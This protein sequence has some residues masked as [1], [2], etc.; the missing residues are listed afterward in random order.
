[1]VNNSSGHY[2][3]KV[4]LALILVLA[5]VLPNFESPKTIA[6]IL[7]IVV[8]LLRTLIYKKIRLRRPD[9]IATGIILLIA[10]SFFSTIV[11]IP[12]PNMF[13]GTWGTFLYCS[14]FWIIYSSDLINK[15]ASAIAVSLTAGTVFGL[16]FGLYDNHIGKTPHLQFHSAGIVTESSIYLGVSLIMTMGLLL[17]SVH[18]YA[19]RS[20][21]SFQTILWVITFFLM[22]TGLFVMA[23]RGAIL[24]FILAA[25]VSLLFSKQKCFLLIVFLTIPVIV[26]FTTQI[27][28]KFDQYRAIH[29]TTTAV[30][31]LQID[32]S[33]KLR[34]DMWRIGLAHFAQ[35][36]HKL[37]GIGPKNFPS[38]K[39]SELKFDNKTALQD[40]KL[41]HAHNLF[42][43]KLV[44][45]G[46]LGLSAMIFFF[47]N[48]GIG[49]IQHIRKYH[50]PAWQWFAALGALL[51][52]VIAGFFNT[53]WHNEHAMQSMILF[54]LFLSYKKQEA[55]SC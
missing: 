7:L 41:N 53:P 42:I 19:L 43:T 24:A 34:L 12:F 30:A 16:A 17:K 32:Y 45:E 46:I 13:K 44:E 11:N 15:R 38:I 1:M 29:K 10:S 25:L 36:E 8:Y 51:V 26:F 3:A 54:A 47:V 5:F 31:N 52:P 9:I 2:L 28:N 21:T 33:D 20:K 27:P 40:N 4:E 48:I 55:L 6:A 50:D 35:K 37:F 39:A 14:V 18:S 22:A 23:S 49:L